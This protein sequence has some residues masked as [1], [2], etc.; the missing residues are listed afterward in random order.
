MKGNLSGKMKGRGKSWIMEHNVN[1]QE[2]L[3]G[4]NRLS[5]FYMI[6]TA[7]KATSAIILPCR[8]NLFTEPLP[9]ND[10]AM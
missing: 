7:Q 4:T 10:R 1:K 3:G 5:P 6:W 9:I 2:I 8:G